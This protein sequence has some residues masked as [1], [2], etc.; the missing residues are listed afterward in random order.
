MSVREH[1]EFVD[2][3]EVGRRVAGPTRLAF[4]IGDSR[5]A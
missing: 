3:V 5:E 2:E 4:E 1:A